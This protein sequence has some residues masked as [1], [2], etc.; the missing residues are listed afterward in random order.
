ML[1]KKIGIAVLALVVIAIVGG[2]WLVHNLKVYEQMSQVLQQDKRALIRNS[3]LV[4]RGT[5]QK[6][7]PGEWNDPY[8]KTGMIHT[9]VAIKV[10]EAFKGTYDTDNPV[11]LR[12][13]KGRVGLNILKHD[14]APDFRTGED[15]ILFLNK[16]PYDDIYYLTGMYQG[17]FEY[18]GGK[19]SDK[20]YKSYKGWNGDTI[21]LVNFRN[22]VSAAL[23]ANP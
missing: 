13:D 3:D 15:V 18:S 14:Q 6:I 23:A 2:N 21:T 17:K 22:E 9:D 19:G 16:D 8:N 4:V 12:N 10:A 7:Y 20:T 11:V 1:L 5:V